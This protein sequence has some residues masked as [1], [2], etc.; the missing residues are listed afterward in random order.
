MNARPT[1]L[2]REQANQLMRDE[3]QRCAELFASLD[4]ADFER[5]TECPGWDVRQMAA[6]I[7]GMAEMVASMRE[8]RRQQRIAVRRASS[9]AMVVDELTALQVDE[10]A[11]WSGARISARFAARWPKAAAGRRRVPGFI[12]RRSM[13]GARL[14]G[15]DETWTL[16]YLMD[17]ILT[18]DPWM[19]RADISRAV[20]RPMVLT[21][22]HDGVLVADVVAE[23][24]ERHGKDYRLHLTGPAGGDWQ[25]GV[26][27][28][29]L[30]LDAV[31]F[32]R[33]VSRRQGSVGLDYLLSTEVPF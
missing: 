15:S 19:H 30:E 17:V 23:W 31:E 8:T 25:V 16:G 29:E 2:P 6:H 5:A 20:C 21:A 11:D 7:L 1:S 24:S 27:G 14:N 18:R 3:Y 33:V 32:C 26:N 9:P 13:Y 22:E 10:R 12:R 4:V 28:P